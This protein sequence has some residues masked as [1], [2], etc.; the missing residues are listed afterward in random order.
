MY[1]YT[2]FSVGHL[3]IDS[4]SK[5]LGVKMASASGGYLGQRNVVLGE[6]E[7]SLTL[8][9]PSAPPLPRVI[10]DAALTIHP[11]E[12]F[13]N[14]SGP[15]IATTLRQ[16]V[17][18]PKS[19]IVIHD[20][21]S[22]KPETLSLKFGGSANGHNGVKSII[23]ALGGDIGFHRIRVGIGRNVDVD[24]AEYVM[25]KLSNEERRFWGENGVGSLM[26]LKEIS[27]IAVQS[28]G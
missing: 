4:L 14:I 2:P 28:L 6:T 18:S 21:L 25:Y 5:S 23:S 11:P 9:K 19:M 20:S 26:V 15:P 8:Y 1:M 3:L 27:K 13:M 16:T 17:K 24:A 12:S 22:H 7:I 10:N